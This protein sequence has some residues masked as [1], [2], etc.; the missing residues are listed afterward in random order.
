[1][2]E[3]ETQLSVLNKTDKEQQNCPHKHRR[4]RES[5]AL[6]IMESAGQRTCLSLQKGQEDPKTLFCT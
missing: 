6:G 4:G 3:D 1:M 2:E 5:K